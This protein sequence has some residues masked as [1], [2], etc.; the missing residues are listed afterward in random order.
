MSKNPEQELFQQWLEHPVTQHLRQWAR[1]RRE[2]LKEDWAT[3]AFT[4]VFD[5]EMAMKNAGATG[6]CSAYLE[7]EEMEFDLIYGDKDDGKQIG[8]SPAGPGSTD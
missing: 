6:A 8:A 4:G 3:G 7:I 1:S 5:M 2:A